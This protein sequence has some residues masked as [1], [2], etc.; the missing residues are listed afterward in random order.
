VIHVMIIIDMMITNVINIQIGENVKN[1]HR[2]NQIKSQDNLKG[3]IRPF[4]RR[5][6]FEIYCSM[7]NL[8]SADKVSRILLLLTIANIFSK[9][10]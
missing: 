9:V 2:M 6:I 8:N 3:I 10:S 7:N 4:C 1:I 5:F